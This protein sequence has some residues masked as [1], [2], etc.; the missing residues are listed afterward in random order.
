MAKL[1]LHTIFVIICVIS[2]S[3]SVRGQTTLP[4]NLST[5]DP[6]F[7]QN[8]LN[9]GSQLVQ[10]LMDNGNTLK[11]ELDS[12][13]G[14]LTYMLQNIITELSLT[15]ANQIELVNQ[16][17]TLSNQLQYGMYPDYNYYDYYGNYWDY[18]GYGYD[19]GYDYPWYGYGYD[20]GYDYPWY[21]NAALYKKKK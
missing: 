18:P 7:D 15:N 2:L 1:P 13:E 12:L 10:V 19:Y 16:I 6:G 17:T 8:I 14:N 4:P 11:D 21:G 9:L 3:Q 5:G 20:Y